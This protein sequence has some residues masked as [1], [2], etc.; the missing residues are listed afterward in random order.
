MG[1]SICGQRGSN[2]IYVGSIM[3]G[4]VVQQDGRI[5]VGDMILQV[6]EVNFEHLSNDQAVAELRKAISKLG[7][8]QLLLA[9]HSWLRSL[10]VFGKRP[11]EN[12]AAEHKLN[13]LSKLYPVRPIDAMAWVEHTKQ[14]NR[15]SKGMPM[16]E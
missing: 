14:V 4:G 9:K 7:P 15:S 16:I 5:S 10:N 6:N 12:V 2:G 1:I 8:I 13:L 11:A 3:D